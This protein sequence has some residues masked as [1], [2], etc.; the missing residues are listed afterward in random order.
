MCAL[1]E[2]RWPL[3]PFRLALSDAL[4]ITLTLSDELEL[5]L[6]LSDALNITLAL[7]DALDITRQAIAHDLALA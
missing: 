7:S 3:P 4:E 2:P 1:C 5:T 6:A